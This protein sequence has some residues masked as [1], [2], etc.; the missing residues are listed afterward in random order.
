[1][2]EKMIIDFHVHIREE[3][4]PLYQGSPD[5]YVRKMDQ[6]G[7][8]KMCILGVDLGKYGAGSNRRDCQMRLAAYEKK[9][10]FKT[11]L[12]NRHIYEFVNVHPDRL[13][14]FGSLHPDSEYNLEEEFEKCVNDYGF[15]GIKLYPL[16]G[17]YPDDERMYPVYDKAEKYGSVILFHTG[18]KDTGAMNMKYD[19]PIF[20]DNISA[21]FL[22][23]KLVMAHVGYPWIDEA[24]MV[25]FCNRNIFLEISGLII[26]ELFTKTPVVKEVLTKILNCATLN[27][28]TIFGSDG[29]RLTEKYLKVLR[30]ADYISPEDKKKILGETADWLLDADNE[31]FRSFLY[32]ELPKSLFARMELKKRE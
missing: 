5:D 30:E 14:G 19:N 22:E 17:F 11:T 12:S 8:D 3:G 16:T 6:L 10:G 32:D 31:Q 9:I 1:L 29:P 7:I 23:L 21:E 28:K 4:T 26:F 25:A 13:V 24:L 15:K 27:E 2:E 20:L 18:V